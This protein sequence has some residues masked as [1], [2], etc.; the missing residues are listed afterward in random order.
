MGWTRSDKFGQTGAYNITL[1][2][3]RN[4]RID[5]TH[6]SNT[7]H[8]LATGRDSTIV[9][10]GH[11]SS[12]NESLNLNARVQ[13]R[14]PGGDSFALQP[15]VVIN[16]STGDNVFNQTQSL[17]SADPTSQIRCLHFDHADTESSKPLGHGQV[18]RAVAAQAG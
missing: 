4:E 18:A 5:D 15:F 16:R 17:C 3:T 2:A 13:W 11:S 8:L 10:E 12:A 6:S 7:T 1:N 14:N 9:N